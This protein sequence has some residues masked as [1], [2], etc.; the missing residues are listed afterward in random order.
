MSSNIWGSSSMFSIGGFFE[1]Q[2]EGQKKLTA[3]EKS[4]EFRKKK[5]YL[6]RR[7]KGEYIAP[8]ETIVFYPELTTAIYKDGMAH[9]AEEKSLNEGRFPDCTNYFAFEA[10]HVWANRA[11]SNAGILQEYGFEVNSATN[12]TL[13][14]SINETGR[15]FQKDE[16]AARFLAD[17]SSSNPDV[18]V[19]FASHNSQGFTGGTNT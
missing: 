9:K 19:G 6:R 16:N 10:A 1:F 13:N 15:A 12:I 8:S 3:H 2:P 5:D 18:K 14:F 17:V 7:D 11:I 4:L